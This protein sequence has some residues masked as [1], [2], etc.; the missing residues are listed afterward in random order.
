MNSVR[1]TFFN[2]L[3]INSSPCKGRLGFEYDTFFQLLPLP[4]LAGMQPICPTCM[5][6]CD[7]LAGAM[8]SLILV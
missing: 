3:C 2:H 7:N 6:A 1:S 8:D 4:P 5:H